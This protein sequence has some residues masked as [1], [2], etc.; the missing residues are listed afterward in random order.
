[1]FDQ[2]EVAGREFAK[3][4]A[5]TV[6]C[7]ARGDIEDTGAL[8]DVTD[9]RRFANSWPA[10]IHG[11][12]ERNLDDPNSI[13]FRKFGHE[14]SSGEN[15]GKRQL[16]GGKAGGKR[17]AAAKQGCDGNPRTN[18][19]PRSRAWNQRRWREDRVNGGA[20]EKARCT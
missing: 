17:A 3:P 8:K 4:L 11:P 20:H 6:R 5:R 9:P 18:S 7:E 16:L 13:P 19:V 2:F 12:A 10:S 14:T 15:N 1:R